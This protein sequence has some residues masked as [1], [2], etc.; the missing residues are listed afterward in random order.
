MGVIEGYRELRIV[1]DV[2]NRRRLERSMEVLISVR[3]KTK[4]RVQEEEGVNRR[5]FKEITHHEGG[6]CLGN[7]YDKETEEGNRM[8]KVEFSMKESRRKI[9]LCLI[10]SKRV[11]YQTY[12]QVGEV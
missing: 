10:N 9:P 2:Q 5:Q 7:V 1:L 3:V 8:I 11:L 4:G 6:R 12:L